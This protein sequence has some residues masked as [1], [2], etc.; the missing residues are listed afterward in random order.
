ME[1]LGYVII[2]EGV[3]TDPTKVEA[4][5]KWPTPT[6]TTQ[7]RS[8]LGLVGYYT[9]FVKNYGVVCKPLFDALK[10]EGFTWSNRQK[11]AFQFLKTNMTQAPF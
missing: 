9:R 2:A 11:Q 6:N 7:L 1:Y 5:T 3:S 4:I 10:T 8:F